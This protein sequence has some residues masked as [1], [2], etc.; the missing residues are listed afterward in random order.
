MP[1]SVMAP[2]ARLLVAA[3][4]VT[5]TVPAA[6][7]NTAQSKAIAG[8]MSDPAAQP[9]TAGVT[10]QVAPATQAAAAATS[11]IAPTAA[12]SPT[13]AAP[14]QPNPAPVPAA[15]KPTPPKP[16]ITLTFDIDQTRQHM[17]VREYGKVIGSWPISSGRAEFRTPNGAFRPSWMAKMWYSRKYDDA[18]MPHSVFFNGGIAMHATQATGMLGRPASHGCIRQA[19]ANAARS[20]AL[21]QKHGLAHTRVTVRGPP[22]DS[23]PEMA[24]RSRNAPR[25]ARAAPMRNAFATSSYT[26]PAY[27]NS[28]RA[29]ATAPSNVRQV[30][31]VDS[32]GN[33][34][35]GY[36]AANDPRLSGG[37]RRPAYSTYSGY[38]AR[39]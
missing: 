19:P 36:I 39:W 38:G 32:W 23:A 34:R 22:R 1:A 2:V 26:S 30:I 29:Y 15:T 28:G 25:L 12:P 21:V 4:V 35:I 8:V 10:A 16:A 11:V 6:L 24:D 18:P 27:A 33:R 7:A 13:Q 20:Y 9:S 3:L 17:T 5:A 31:F 37:Y 14:A